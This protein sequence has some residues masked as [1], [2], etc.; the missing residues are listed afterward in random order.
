MHSIA[1]HKHR[2]FTCTV[3]STRSVVCAWHCLHTMLYVSCCLHAPCCV[4]CVYVHVV[5]T[6]AVVYG[7]YM[8]VV[9][10][11][12]I[13]CMHSIV[14]HHA[15]FITPVLSQGGQRMWQDHGL[16]DTSPA[17]SWERCEGCIPAELR[18]PLPAHEA[19]GWG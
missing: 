16:G 15:M 10:T 14:L 6:H 5:C 19:P 9:C 17:V 2:V 12:G 18:S 11:H 4:Y 3:L 7:V 1:L 8:H 13:V